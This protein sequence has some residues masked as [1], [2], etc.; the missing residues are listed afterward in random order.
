MSVFRNEPREALTFIRS[1]GETFLLD[2]PPTRIL[3]NMTGWGKPPEELH[4]IS[5]PYQHGNTLVSYRLAPRII[6]VDLGHESC[7]RSEWFNMRS[8]LVN[9][10]GLNNASPNSPV[11]GT[12]LWQYFVNGVLTTRALDVYLTKGLGF[13]PLDG[14]RANSVLESLE[15]T[16]HNP[17]IYDPTQITQSIDTWTAE[18]RFPVTP[19]FVLGTSSGSKVITYTGTWE[20]HPE[21]QIIGPAGNVYIENITTGKF[22]RFMYGVSVGETVTF[23]LTYNDISVTNNYNMDLM[24]YVSD[25]S[26]I[27]EF[28]LQPSPIVTGGNNT[29]KVYLAGNGATTKVNV[30]Y[31]N[32]YYGV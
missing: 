17:V 19:P 1:D 13:A 6:S 14:W 24:A 2:M 11:P 7:S 27:G 30:L 16:A 32:R 23:D 4:T 22:I 9:E 29:I 21:I 25:D 3:M 12:L 5:G 31:Y 20:E 28:S 26:A 18:L 15:F 8:R 10:M